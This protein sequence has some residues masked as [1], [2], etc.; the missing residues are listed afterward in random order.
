MVASYPRYKQ[1]PVGL[2]VC[3]RKLDIVQKE[4]K[5]W[6]CIQCNAFQAVCRESFKTENDFV[7]SIAHDL[8]CFFEMWS[9]NVFLVYSRCSE[10]THPLHNNANRSGVW[11]QSILKKQ[12]G[13]LGGRPVTSLGHQGGKEFSERSPSFWNYVRD[14]FP[15]REKNVLGGLR[16]PPWLRACLVALYNATSIAVKQTCWVWCGV[17]TCLLILQNNLVMMAMKLM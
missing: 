12:S 6:L 3:A 2:Q 9:A 8:S 5:R 15:G 10:G 4:K 11:C 16:P 1:I 17:K 14:I 13:G 7:G